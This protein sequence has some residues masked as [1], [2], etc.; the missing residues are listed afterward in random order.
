MVCGADCAL[1]FA[2]SKSL[3]AAVSFQSCPSAQ[4]LRLEAPVSARLR[5]PSRD[6][7]QLP[8]VASSA[9]DKDHP[10]SEAAASLVA[11]I[12]LR[13]SSVMSWAI[14]SSA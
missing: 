11:L 14:E 8:A 3:D 10:L 7:F 1:V 13:F 9:C 4:V 5:M 12:V 6:G 2:A